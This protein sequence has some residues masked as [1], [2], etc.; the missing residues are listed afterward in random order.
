MEIPNLNPKATSTKD[1]LLRIHQEIKQS[2]T[3]EVPEGWLTS[4]EIAS[5]M[6]K[7]IST[8]SHFLADAVR[9]GKMESRRFRIRT[10]GKVDSIPHYRPIRKG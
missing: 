7:A 5:E 3:D 2:S 4:N 10:L 1:L 9:A 6:G 8:A